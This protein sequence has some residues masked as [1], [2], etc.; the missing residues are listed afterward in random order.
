MANVEQEKIV[1]EIETRL[2]EDRDGSL[3]SSVA[4]GIDEQIA[5]I[6]TALKRGVPPAEYERLTTLKSGLESASLILDRT[7]SHYHG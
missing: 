4:A 1:M 3:R 7:W 6:D 2:K 5:G